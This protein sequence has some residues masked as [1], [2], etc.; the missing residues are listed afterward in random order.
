MARATHPPP[1]AG[2]RRGGGMEPSESID[3][4][5]AVRRFSHETGV[6]HGD[7][8]GAARGPTAAA[9]RLRGLPMGEKGS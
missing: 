8:G 6:M 2:G 9:A 5:Q 1:L 4:M 7:G 3:G